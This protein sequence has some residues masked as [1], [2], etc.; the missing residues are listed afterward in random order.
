MTKSKVLFILPRG[1]AIRI[2][3]ILALLKNYQKIMK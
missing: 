3:F 2:L 1:E